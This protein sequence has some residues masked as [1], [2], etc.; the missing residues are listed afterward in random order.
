MKSAMLYCPLI[1]MLLASLPVSGAESAVSAADGI[2]P[3]FTFVA[4]SPA[5]GVPAG[6]DVPIAL[7]RDGRPTGVAADSGGNLFIADA[8]R[9]IVLRIDAEGIVR[10]AAGSPGERG[11][12]DGWGS[13]ARFDAPAAVTVGTSGELFVAE[14]GTGRLRLLHPN[15]TVSTLAAGFD[16]PAALA[17][18]GFR[19]VLLVADAGRHVVEQVRLNGEVVPLAG[20]GRRGGRD[21]DALSA[22]LDSPG[23][24]ALDGEGNLYIADTGN[25]VIRRLNPDGKM[26][27]VARGL[28]GPMGII[29][30]G[31]GIL[32]V[33]CP[34]AHALYRVALD[35]SRSLLAGAP[36]VPGAQ[37]GEGG[38]ARFCEP[39]GLAWDSA[40]RTLYVADGGN[41]AVVVG[42]KSLADAAIADAVWG[43]TGQLRRLDTFPRTATAWS[44]RVVGAPRGS[45]AALSSPFIRNPE[46]T[47]DLEGAYTLQLI[48]RSETAQSLSRVRLFADCPTLVTSPL[49][50]AA[51][52]GTSTTFQVL[53]SQYVNPTYQWKKDAAVIPGEVFDT[54]GIAPV[55]AGDAGSYMCDITDDC[56]PISSTPAVLFV[57]TFPPAPVGDTLMVVKGAQGLQLNWTDIG[58][59]SEYPVYEDTAAS[60][61]FAALTGTA[62]DGAGGLG[63]PLPVGDRFYKVAGA[64]DCGTGPL[65]PCPTIT[66][67]PSSLPGGVEG[68]AYNQT[69]SQTGAGPG[70]QFTVSSGD[71][72]SGLNLAPD[73]GALTG[74][75][76]PSGTHEFTL[77]A[78][79]AEGCFGYRAYSITITCNTIAV[80]PTS[81]PNGTQG[82]PYSQTITASGGYG[83]YTFAVTA[84]ALPDGLNLASGGALS[85]TPTAVGTFDFTVTA[86]D[87]AACQ[88]SRAY[89]ITIETACGTITVN[90]STLSDGVYS[91]AYTPVQ[92]TQ[93]GGTAPISWSSTGVLPTG[94][95][96]SSAG[97]LSGTPT[98][99]G[100]Y[101][102]T[103]IATDTNN[104]TGSRQI[105]FAVNPKATNDAYNGGV[106]HTQ[107]VVNTS[108]P[109]TPAVFVNSATGVLGNDAG[110][111]SLSAALLSGP[112]NGAVVLNANGTFTYTP[113]V[114]F[115][116]PSD[117][118]SYTLTDGNG[119]TATATVTINLS[120]KVWYVNNTYGGG[121]GASDGRSH[122]PFTT[123]TAAGG[124]T[125]N[126][127]GD[128]IYVHQ[129]SGTTTGGITLKP[130]QTLWGQ[131]TTFTLNNL[132]IAATA[133]PT[134]NGTVNLASSVTVSSLN[135]STGTATGITNPAAVTGVTIT[136]AVAVT[137]TTGTAV[138]LN[139]A[140]GSFSF[141]SVSANSGANGIVLT[142]QT[143]SFTVTGTGSASSGGSIVNM[144]GADGATAGIGI[145]MNGA[146]SVS[147]AWM[148][149]SGHQNFA[150][151]GTTVSGF[152]MSNTVINGTNGTSDTADEA[153]VSFAGLTG[154][155]S[156]SSCNI[157]GGVEDNVRI[158]NNTGSL[159][160]VTFSNT[161]L[162]ANST[163]LGDNSLYIEGSGTA[164]VNVTFQNGF[165][166]AARGDLFHLNL[167][168]TAS[169]DL[170]FT[171]NT[172]SNNHSAIINGE[173]GLEL[174]G[175]GAGMNPTF[176]FNIANNTFR[177]A[178]GSALLI[179]NSAG[180]GVF[181]GTISGNTIGVQAVANS[182][183]IV[184]SDVWLGLYGGG[185]ITASILNN[186]LYQY[187]AY[188]IYMQSGDGSLGGN[189]TLNATIQGNTISNPGTSGAIMNGVHLNCGTVTGDVRQC[190]ANIGGAGGAANT[191][192][193]SGANGGQDARLR[194][195]MLTTV[196]LPGYTGANNDNAAV[197]VFIQNRN[198]GSETV[199][200]AN[201]VSTGGGGFIGTGSSC[202]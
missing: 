21:G 134:V 5:D 140:G 126:A 176:T 74:T 197:V 163:A 162:G 104:C 75:L 1:A 159:N 26:S 87:T 90:P 141:Q 133:K 48:A 193:G 19:G 69:I 78:T 23:G 51:C 15:G 139:S 199:S 27:T 52:A 172:C 136:N 76:T 92:F 156:F 35:G 201:T 173:G 135:I 7:T 189:G 100:S 57:G 111:G 106:G 66:V 128:Y 97:I 63:F 200:A 196:R 183:S 83:S 28:P 37:S 112:T 77:S 195:R 191:I 91:V 144:V 142:S 184:G 171:G 202:P 175:G 32:A 93:T 16:R 157:S 95:T 61:S 33:S 108:A 9:H 71:F 165:L 3:A 59:A 13:D 151:R 70:V 2:A 39:S 65:D 50:R 24:L 54:Y 89:S 110:A 73:T 147:L 98:S 45:V 20:S 102:V 44:W 25:G 29:H 82:T 11:S 96:F 149:L 164:V 55:A 4:L 168:N 72:P 10:L 113:N 119:R 116:G 117:A 88:G 115:T 143:G 38:L 42:K 81:L 160:R 53:L 198:N 178:Y 43:D 166:T 17:W 129:G 46:F 68:S 177:D 125:G 150:V 169:S 47:P 14:E 118:F 138:S 34:E 120:Q 30:D 123:L 60:G 194:Q 181:S 56:G 94:M 101:T 22:D 137:T 36:G 85:G 167:L 152:T 127:N 146:Q 187:N 80:N 58:N 99:T 109:S 105:T 8:T 121:S 190:C 64:N 6:F 124:A 12:A 153:C 18:D 158:V 49:D 31:R 107:Y 62:P 180:T 79:D 170:V 145:Y 154:T 114:N 179:V 182:G 192:G 132:T 155:A 86:T 103:F 161:T 67:N 186:A 130:S 40:R 185:T 188:G 41:G 84:G 122:R 148:A 131:G 174:G